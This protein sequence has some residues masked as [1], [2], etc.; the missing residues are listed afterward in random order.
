[1]RELT[2]NERSVLAHV[3]I[4]PDAWVAGA[5]EDAL[6]E[7]VAKWQASYDEASAEPGY[8][9]RADRP[10]QEPAVFVATVEALEAV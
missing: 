5:T 7:K 2:D 3:V 9:P 4:D 8:L 1:M 6:V 10:D